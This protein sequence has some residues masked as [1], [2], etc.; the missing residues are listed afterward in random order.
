M[1]GE[2]LAFLTSG[3]DAPGMNAAIRGIVRMALYR[4]CQPYAVLEGFRGLV[5]GGDMITKMN[6]NDVANI[7]NE[8]GT[9]IRSSR[10]PE[11]RERTHRKKA[12][13][14]L[15]RLGID[16]LIVIG[17]DGSLTGADL[18]RQEWK[19]LLN[20]LVG[21]GKIDKLTAKT[22]ENMMIVCL[23]G[24]IDNDMAGTEITIGANSS[25]HR[26]IEAVDCI[27]STASSHQRA[28]VIEVM[29]RH[30]GWL[31]L[32]SAISCGADWLMIPEDP[33][34]DGWEERM[35]DTVLNNRA[36]GRTVSIVMV[37]EGA[38]DRKNQPIKSERIKEILEKAGLDARV[39][40]LGH[41]QRGGSPSAF[42]RYLGT[43]QGIK[44][45]EAILDSTPETPSLLV[46]MNENKITY[47]PLMDCVIKTQAAANEMSALNFDKAFS[48]RDPDFRENY[49]MWAMMHGEHEQCAQRG[50]RIGVLNCGAPCG[51]MNAATA[52][53][54][55]YGR[56]KGFDTVGIFNGFDGLS[57]GDVREL[58]VTDIFGI[59]GKG[60]SMLGTNRSLPGENMSLLAQQIQKLRLEALVIIGGFEAYTALMQLTKARERYSVL[61]IP[62]VVIPATISNNVPGTE[63]SVGSDTAL[64]VIVQSCDYIRQ[65]ASSSRKRVFVVDVQGGKCGYLATLAGLAS[66]ASREYIP[67]EGIRIKDLQRDSQHLR[68]RFLDDRAQGRIVIRNELCSS[69]YSAE[70]ISKI[71]EEE[72]GGAYDSRWVMLGHLQQ[73]GSPSPLDRIRGVRLAV[74]ATRYLESKLIPNTHLETNC[75]VSNE[76]NSTKVDL[77]FT[78]LSLLNPASADP[79]TSADSSS[80]DL[81]AS[82]RS[83]N[84]ADDNGDA[85]L[86]GIRGSRVR[87]TPIL[88]L[89]DRTDHKNRRP[90]DQWWLSIKR[91]EASKLGRIERTMSESGDAEGAESPNDEKGKN[92]NSK[93]PNRVDDPTSQI[94]MTCFNGSAE[95]LTA[96]H[97]PLLSPQEISRIDRFR[98]SRSAVIAV[99]ALALFTDMV[100]YDVIVPILPLLL[101][102]V[103]RDESSVGL[104]FAIYAVGYLVAT[105]VFG[106]WSDRMRDRRFPMLL[107]QAGLA[108]ATL[109]FA[110]GKV[111]WVLVLARLLQGVAA[112]VSWTLGLA[113]LADAVPGSEL[114]A[115]MGVVFGFHTLGYFVGPLMGGI[116][117]HMVRIE[118]PFVL[119]A[120]LCFIDLAARAFI[121]P[122]P[123]RVVDPN[124]RKTTLPK[125]LCFP[126]VLVI[127]LVVV[128]TSSS[129]SAVETLLSAHLQRAFGLDVMGVSFAMMAIVVPSVL[130]SFLA[131]RWADKCCCYTM[132]LVAMFLYIP[133]TPFMGL[134]ESLGMFLSASVYFGATSAVLQAPTL[135]E[136]GAIVTRLGGG[137]Y[138]QVYAI[139]NVCYSFG[140]LLGPLAASAINPRYGFPV[141]MSRWE[142]PL[143]WNQAYHLLYTLCPVRSQSSQMQT[144]TTLSSKTLKKK[145]VFKTVFDTPHTQWP[146]V[147]EATSKDV[148]TRSISE[149]SRLRPKTGNDSP[150]VI[151]LNEVTR[152]LEARTLAGVLACRDDLQYPQVVA[153]LPFQ[154]RLSGALV[155]A[156]PAGSAG[157]LSTL[158]G[159]KNVSVVGIRRVPEMEAYIE[160]LKKR[161]PPNEDLSVYQSLVIHRIPVE[162]KPKRARNK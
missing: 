132:I 71:L 103:G 30:C 80:V 5:H 112:A 106:I 55:W 43:M 16:K 46:S 29:G 10:C 47:R 143:Y 39:T 157:E 32:N 7:I 77:S 6:W 21:D 93:N 121:R 134:A 135:P 11:F 109:M 154:S 160:Y 91:A 61:R 137:S 119:C 108:G 9:I 115:A 136:M 104:L 141:S 25:L 23:V 89:E 54:F 110:F 41:V 100:L 50:I 116:L 35:S 59:I 75:K 161:L 144:P 128:C 149:F 113:L 1:S 33:P 34:L 158:F 26:I 42:D 107:G 129:F 74:L 17:G 120:G 76:T 36:M 57:Q 13:E 118:A 81:H 97:S 117:T 45:V 67:E 31:A 78:N 65:S 83:D 18:F 84:D 130:F 123:I 90:T 127:G 62:M 72:G 124:I 146:K 37:A 2:K 56:S 162:S 40:T 151:G 64:N 105:P 138:A 153:H 60:G 148:L 15:V 142:P 51:G 49:Q 66:A 52:A 3:G 131:G 58:N 79:S 22:F 92:C 111:F 82:D 95:T 145:T 4:G 114:G 70:M 101:K 102:S 126:E 156:L 85:V 94:N 48:L 38:V 73:G 159:I 28:F 98:G 99:V 27:H 20:E 24:S 53:T 96:P 147:D 12:A 63:Y 152:C 69:T 150:V 19:S 86:I 88:S 14:N 133:A 87:L 140:M 125:L 122:P 68:D 139:L 44:A 8:G 155:V